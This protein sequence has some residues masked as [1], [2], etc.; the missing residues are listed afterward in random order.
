MA[1]F[2]R[3][4]IW[5]DANPTGMIADFRL[6]WKQAGGNRWRIAA[7]AG[8]CTLG[9]F[10]LMAQQQ[11]Q[12]PYKS[13]EV[14]WISTFKPGRTDAQIEA[15]NIANQKRKEW[16][17][18]QQAKRDKE[19][20]DMYKSRGPDV[21]HG[22]GQDDRAGQRRKGRQGQGGPGCVRTAPG[23]TRRR[24]PRRRAG[25]PGRYV[26]ARQPIGCTASVTSDKRWLAAAAALS[27][28]ARPLSRPNPGVGALIV[29]NGAVIA[30]GW[31]QR[32][33]RPHAEAVALEAAGDDARGATLYV[34]LEPCAHASAR[35]PACADLVAASGLARVV[36]GC[37]DPDPRTSG[38]GMARIRDAGI[39]AEHAALPGLH[40]QPVRLSDAAPPRPSRSHA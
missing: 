31:T 10:F 8:A 26:I 25:P 3:S 38:A 6:V 39:A 28:R 21:G 12:A 1:L 17:E 23:R 33:G 19:V 11:G 32:G 27:A 22:C 35:G 24:C 13:P 16:V 34:T 36:I 7:L 2:K 29:R 40:A 30:R 37:M 4:G 5:K 18:A 9:L 14:I 20:Q 15:S